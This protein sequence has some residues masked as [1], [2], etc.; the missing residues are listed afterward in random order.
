MR[1][2]TA[3]SADGWVLIRFSTVH[4]VWRVSWKANSGG[5]PTTS[6]GATLGTALERALQRR[7]ELKT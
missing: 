6:S 2:L 4:A 1:E 7:L 3:R 5:K